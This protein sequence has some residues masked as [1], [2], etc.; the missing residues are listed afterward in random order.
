MSEP[1][2]LWIALPAGAI[3]MMLADWLAGH[4]RCQVCGQRVRA[5]KD[6]GSVVIAECPNGCGK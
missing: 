5:L 6:N 4:P 1:V 3:V 2:M